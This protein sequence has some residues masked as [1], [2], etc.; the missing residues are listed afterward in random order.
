MKK[1]IL[2]LV[3][4]GSLLVGSGVTFAMTNY[5]Y[6]LL[7]DQSDSIKQELSDHYDEEIER[8]G[9]Q[10]HNDMVMYVETKKNEV[11]TNAHSYLDD[12]LVNEQ[13]DRMNEH[14]KEID[15]AADQLEAELK[16]YI[17]SKFE[18]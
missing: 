17:D 3:A 13:Q 2:V 8:I 15:K 14:T 4:V 18:Q 5:Y 11:V 16:A 9:T 6:Q 7:L 10:V 12:K 1:K